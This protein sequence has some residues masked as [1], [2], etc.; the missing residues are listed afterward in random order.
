MK[1]TKIRHLL[2]ILRKEEKDIGKIHFFRLRDTIPLPLFKERMYA[3][4]NC[5]PL[6]DTM[7]LGLIDPYEFAHANMLLL[8]K[9]ARKK[10]HLRFYVSQVYNFF[11][12]PTEESHCHID[13]HGLDSQEKKRLA[14]DFGVGMS[15]L[16]MVKCFGLEWDTVAH[17]PLKKE[18]TPD[19]IGFSGEE[20]YIFEAKGT[21]IPGAVE[22]AVAKGKRQKDNYLQPANLKLV[23]CTFIP[24]ND[25]Q[26]LPFTVIDDPVPGPIEVTKSMAKMRHALL[27]LNFAGFYKSSAAYL[28]FLSTFEKEEEIKDGYYF[29]V[30]RY[31]EYARSFYRTYTQE[32]ESKAQLLVGDNV[33]IG[34]MKESAD[35]SIFYRFRFGLFFE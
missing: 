7:Y 19:F 18:P 29:N 14:E 28:R 2:N 8:S 1:R 3:W 11:C 22:A 6:N 13:F 33:F 31:K 20:P 4:Q 25:S 35:V 24:S 5:V 32:S 30:P 34:E 21:S 23:F 12:G 9:A 26:T 10:N 17:L 16:F 15:A 27:M